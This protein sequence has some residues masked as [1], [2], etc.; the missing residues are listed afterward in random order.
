MSCWNFLK[1]NLE[2]F[3]TMVLIYNYIKFAFKYLKSVID[4]LFN[5]LW[6]PTYLLTVFCILYK[7]EIIE[8]F[9][10]GS[11]KLDRKRYGQCSI[12]LPTY[13][14]YRSTPIKSLAAQAQDSL[15]SLYFINSNKGREILILSHLITLVFFQ[16]IKT[17]SIKQIFKRYENDP[18]DSSTEVE[19]LVFIV[20]NN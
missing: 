5:T 7:H 17:I 10:N 6:V 3:L 9:W 4:I 14:I 20:V 12:S 19:K 15:P 8:G 13:L 18:F 1:Y 2:F 11:C 16:T